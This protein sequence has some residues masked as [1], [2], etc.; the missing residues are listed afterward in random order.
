MKITAIKAQVKQAGRYSIFVDEK[1]AFSLS[2][3]ALLGSKL[4]SGQELTGREV[5]DYKKL[6]DDDKVFQR[7]LNFIALRPRSKWEVQSY[8]ERKKVPPALVEII[9]NKLNKMG[10][11]DDAK[12]AESYVHDRRLLRP[13][14][15]RKMS[16]ELKKKR[17]LE[18]VI[19]QA[20]G[21]EDEP[22]QSALQALIARKR[23]QSRYQ[24]DKKLMQYLAG[25]GF[26]Y[27]DIKSALEVHEAID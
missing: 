12:F 13:T 4:V 6:S 15:R 7:V 10:Y 2:D 23:C 14:S 22:E 9:L 24:D 20:V 5:D 26:G 17:V 25:Q 8:L 18:E 11:I 16:L 21:S 1:Y 19:R 3:T 27:G